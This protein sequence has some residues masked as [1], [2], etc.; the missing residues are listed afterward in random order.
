[1]NAEVSY[2]K[3]HKLIREQQV[4][5]NPARPIRAHLTP[6]RAGQADFERAIEKGANILR[7]YPDSRWADDALELIGRSYFMLGQYFSADIKFN[8][9]LMASSNPVM[10]QRAILWKGLVFLETNRSN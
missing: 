3:G 6:V 9:V 1:Y 10:R 7:K 5:Y 2:E 8:E 4:T